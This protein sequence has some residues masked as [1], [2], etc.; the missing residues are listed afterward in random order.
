MAVTSSEELIEVEHLIAGAPVA[1]D[2]HEVGVDAPDAVPYCSY[3]LASEDE[4][5]VAVMAARRALRHWRRTTWR[6][7]A[8]L[9]RRAARNLSLHAGALAQVIVRETGKPI[10]QAEAEVRRAARVFEDYANLAGAER[11][12]AMPDYS[13]E[14]WGLELREPAGVAALIGTWNLPAQISAAKIGAALAAGCTVVFKPSPRAP[15]VAA[16]LVEALVSAGLPPDCLQVVH[17]GEATTAELVSHPSVAVVSF[18]GR[19]A[20]GRAVMRAMSSGL[21]K[22]VLELG[23]KSANIVFADADCDGAVAGALS[24]IVRNQG[25][26]CTAGS[27][28]LVE[29]G[30]LD[31]FVSGLCNAVGRVQVGDPYLPQTEVGAIRHLDL[32]QSIVSELEQATARGGEILVGGEPVEVVGRTGSY[33]R[34]AVVIGLSNED[35]LARHELFGPVAVLIPFDGI[36]EAIELANDS[37]YGLAAGIW[38]SN[39]ETLEHA[40]S[41]LEAGTIYV[42]SYG[43]ID[44]IPLPAAGRKSSGFGAEVG[45]RGIEEFAT[46]KSVHLPRRRGRRP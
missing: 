36:E 4:L 33:L 9:L 30:L 11:H 5:D 45:I 2:D 31:P 19:D 16:Y 38:S 29:R 37:D 39:I 20:A 42:N 14:V 18:T 43:R 7:R 27:R 10:K 3:P 34:P 21:A 25:A 23:G 6:E 32:Y 15:C 13:A 26:T 35:E 12:S 28:I 46:S 1:G 24:G 22:P 17:G 8:E 44:N 41:E 40:W